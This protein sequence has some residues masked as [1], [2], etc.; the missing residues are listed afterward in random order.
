MSAVSRRQHLDKYEVKLRLTYQRPT[1]VLFSFSNIFF[2]RKE[3]KGL[4]IFFIA[5]FLRVGS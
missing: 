3:Y 2:Q 5:P 1:F 4:F